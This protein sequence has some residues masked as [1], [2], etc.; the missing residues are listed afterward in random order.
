MEQVINVLGAGFVGGRYCE[1][2]P[3]QLKMIEMIIR[4]KLMKFYISSQP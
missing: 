1:L 4:L 2:T 3:T